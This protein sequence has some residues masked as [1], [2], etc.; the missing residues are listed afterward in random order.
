VSVI[1][2]QQLATSG[3]LDHPQTLLLHMPGLTSCIPL[4]PDT[5]TPLYLRF[6]SSPCS[7]SCRSH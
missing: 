2:L 1:I 3:A 5:P 6:C 4:Q 7:C